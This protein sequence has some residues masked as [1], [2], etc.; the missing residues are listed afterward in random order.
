MTIQNI[1]DVMERIMSLN[2]NLNEESLRTLLSASGWDREDIMEG[3]RI[4]RTKN[5]NTVV[6][7]PIRSEMV[8]PNLVSEN[9]EE[10]KVNAGD[11]V[12]NVY[13]F[14]LKNRGEASTSS[15]IETEDIVSPNLIK[16]NPVESSNTINIIPVGEKRKEGKSEE[17]LPQNDFLIPV[18]ENKITIKEEGKKGGGLGKVLFY[19]LLLII[20]GILAAYMLVP[21][22]KNYVNKKLFNSSS[23]QETLYPNQV[24]INVPD[25]NNPN[26]VLPNNL[27][28]NIPSEIPANEDNTPISNSSMD[29]EELRREIANLKGELEKYK[30]SGG[31]EKTV[32]KYISQRGPTG[33]AGKS[34]RGITTVDATSTG[35]LINYTDG[36]TDIVPYSTTTIL[37]ILSS[38]S[39]CFRDASSTNMTPNPDI[40]L[41]RNAVLNLINK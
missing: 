10:E 21:E 30:N 2:R 8:D 20:L 7:N 6:A 15:P 26:N 23:T 37:N 18:T 24:P 1:E 14:N 16:N 28:N 13:S 22:V 41:D 27:P 19:L 9:I 31:E 38:Q 35:F 33:P 29:I 11:K 36:T 25:V 12:N 34:G 5:K 3:L 32:I 17:K 39:V 40:C 4:F